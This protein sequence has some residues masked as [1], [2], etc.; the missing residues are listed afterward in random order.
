M[1]KAA[2]PVRL[3][4]NLMDSATIAAKQMHRSA[5]EQVEY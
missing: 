5:A 1:A 2:S 4:R 3:D